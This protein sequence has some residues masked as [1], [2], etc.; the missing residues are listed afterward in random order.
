MKHF[1]ELVGRS[2]V[3]RLDEEGRATIKTVRNKVRVFMA[4]WERVNH[5]SIP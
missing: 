2:T 3:G 5:L 1:A 4:Q